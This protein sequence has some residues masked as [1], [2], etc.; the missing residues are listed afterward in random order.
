MSQQIDELRAEIARI[1]EMVETLPKSEKGASSDEKKEEDTATRE[2]KRNIYL[3]KLNKGIIK[4]PKKST[5]EHY[6]VKYDAESKCY[7]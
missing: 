2:N 5:L 3:K 1:R 7:S 4:E 6:G